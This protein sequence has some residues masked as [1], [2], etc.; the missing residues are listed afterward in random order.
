MSQQRLSAAQH[1]RDMDGLDDTVLAGLARSG[2]EF[3]IRA[4]IAR[5]NQRLFRTARSVMRDDGEA[6]DVLQASY[7][8]AFIHLDGFRGDAQLSTWLTRITLNEALGRLRRRRPTTGIEQIDIEASRAG[9]QV[10]PFPLM[11]PAIDP[12]TEMCRN[13]VRRI[14]ERAVDQLPLAFRAVFVM[15][16]VEGLSIEE[17][18][19]QLSI[20]PETV[21]TRLHR[22]RRLMRVAIEAELSGAFGALFPFDGARCVSMADRVMAQLGQQ[23]HAAGP[24]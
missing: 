3:A 11:Q 1:S 24:R 5:H 12:E 21:K 4:I 22:A 6:E 2:D 18:A 7:V 9:G 8:K 19:S 10:I 16:D 17:T 20:K 15:R 13:E 14:L 23:G